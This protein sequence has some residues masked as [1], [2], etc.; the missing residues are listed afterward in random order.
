MVGVVRTAR[1]VAVTGP[2]SFLAFL[3][4]PIA[5]M[6]VGRP[7]F[8]VAAAVGALIVLLADLIGQ[9]AFGT[10][11]MPAG[12]ITGALGAPFLLWLLTRTDRK[13]TRLNSSH[14]AIS[15]AVF[16]LKKK[17]HRENLVT[18]S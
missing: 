1:T 16:C 15:Y 5:R 4:G 13:S 7:S 3:A 14:V 11:D 2:L 6:I 10:T 9:G 12:V 8:P 18:L 17:K